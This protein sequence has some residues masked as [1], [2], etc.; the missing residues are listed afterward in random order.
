M[1]NEFTLHIALDSIQT[2]KSKAE[3]HL[4]N[5][6]STGDTE[7]STDDEKKSK[8]SNSVKAAFIDN[9][10]SK[11]FNMVQQVSASQVEKLGSIYDNQ[12]RQNQI[13]NLMTSVGMATELVSAGV[14]GAVTG[15]VAGP[16]GAAVGAVLAVAA[17]ATKQSI[18]AYNRVETWDVQQYGNTLNE[19]R[20]SERLGIQ[21][22]N[23]NRR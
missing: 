9:I 17:D 3:E 8:L 10:A 20:S 1:N 16:V 21:R 6:T 14:S 18:Q 4:R 19:V 7:N 12:M 22:S 2:D 11:A 13:N 23:R 15:S 5:A